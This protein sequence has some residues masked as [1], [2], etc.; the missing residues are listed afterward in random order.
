MN[1]WVRLP[2]SYAAL[3]TVQAAVSQFHSEELVPL[4][5]HP[6]VFHRCEA[7]KETNCCIFP[8]DTLVNEHK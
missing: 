2:F 8:A 4:M 6:V 3:V 7:E 5:L 1:F